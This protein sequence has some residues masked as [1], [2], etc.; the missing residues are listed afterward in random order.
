[1]GLA[2]QPSESFGA[3]VTDAGDVVIP[4]EQVAGLGLH[5][6]EHLAVVVPMPRTAGSRSVKGLLAHLGPAPGWEAF[7]AASQAAVAEAEAAADRKTGL[8]D[9]S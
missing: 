3:V 4:A 8:A 9:G 6:G 1:M 7:Q 2:R 5:P